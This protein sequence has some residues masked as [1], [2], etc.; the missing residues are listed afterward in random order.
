MKNYH[1]IIYRMRC[2]I[3]GVLF[4]QP[5]G[6]RTKSRG[7]IQSRCTYN[8]RAREIRTR[9]VDTILRIWSSWCRLIFQ[10]PTTCFSAERDLHT[11]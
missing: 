6:E 5:A 4:K 9:I 10:K 7:W 2:F 3:F 1:V 11:D 8:R